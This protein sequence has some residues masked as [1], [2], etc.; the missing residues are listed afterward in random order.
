MNA[1][2]IDALLTRKGLLTPLHTETARR[3][4]AQM[5]AHEASV[6]LLQLDEDAVT[7]MDENMREA[8]LLLTRMIEA[9]T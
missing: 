8:R 3:L 1:A 7:R 2:E 4:R 9:G 5:L 6:A